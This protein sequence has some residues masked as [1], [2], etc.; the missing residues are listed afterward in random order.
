MDNNILDHGEPKSFG[1]VYKPWALFIGSSLLV[2][3]IIHSTKNIFPSIIGLDLIN[4]KLKWGNLQ[5][6]VLTMIVK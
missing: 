6:H 3:R 5:Q 1:R 4:S 2:D